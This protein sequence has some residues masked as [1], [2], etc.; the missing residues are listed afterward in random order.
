MYNHNALSP[1]VLDRGGPSAPAPLAGGPVP[2]EGR[3]AREVTVL[4][5]DEDPVARDFLAENLRA[6]GYLVQV[7]RDRR[8][9]IAQLTGRPPDIALVDVNGQTLG[10]LDSVRSAEPPAGGGDPNV[11]I[12]VLSSG[13]DELQRIRLLQRGGD[14]VVVKPFSYPELRARVEALL[15]RSRARAAPRI[16]RAGPV[17]IDLRTRRVRVGDRGVELSPKEYGL[18]AVLASEP[19]RVHTRDELLHEVWG[20]RAP[21]CTRTLDSHA[22]RLRAKLTACGAPGLVLNVWGV[23]YCLYRDWSVRN[24]AA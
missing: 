13:A 18:L 23:G 19:Q 5:V 20:F 6:D 2:A 17:T 9:A 8:S 16:L 24:E 21:G 14:D 4:V 12:L 7:A 10:L 22:S 3:D 11:P 15:R 1:A